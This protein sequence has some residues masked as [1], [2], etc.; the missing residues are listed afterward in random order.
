MGTQAVRLLG[1]VSF[2]AELRELGGGGGGGGGGWGGRGVQLGVRV[3]GPLRG[4]GRVGGGGGGALPDT[5]S[6]IF[7]FLTPHPTK[8]A[9]LILKSRRNGQGLHFPP[10]VMFI[11]TQTH[12]Q[13][14][15]LSSLVGRAATMSWDGD[16]SCVHPGLWIWNVANLNK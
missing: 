7:A 3:G 12:S 4:G 6:K 9:L 14:S 1:S 11:P 13:L 10:F 8:T 16:M 15:D 2:G 5:S